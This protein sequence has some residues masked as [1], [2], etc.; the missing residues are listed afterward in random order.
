MLTTEEREELDQL[1]VTFF[2]TLWVVAKWK[3]GGHEDLGEVLLQDALLHVCQKSHPWS[4]WNK[5][6]G[7]P[8]V[9]FMRRVMARLL[10]NLMKRRKNDPQVH[11]RGDMT[12]DDFANV[13]HYN[14]PAQVAEDA[15]LFD[16]LRAQ[17]EEDG[18][19]FAVKC[20]DLSLEGVPEYDLQAEALGVDIK[21]VYKANEHIKATALALLEGAKKK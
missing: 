16:K 12:A 15:D 1:Y 4:T 11:F 14:S 10:S 3:C 5:A 6:D 8:F 19:D 18:R 2:P 20:L 9:K 13:G 7:L 21:K 17:L